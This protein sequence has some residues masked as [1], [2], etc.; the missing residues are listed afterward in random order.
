MTDPN[1][2]PDPI[3]PDDPVEPVGDADPQ[4]SD[5]PAADPPADA[6]PQEDLLGRLQRVS[7]DYVNY[8]KRAQRDIVQAREFANEQ[9]IKE[10]LPVLDDMERALDAARSNHDEDDP[11][12]KGMQL[13]HDKAL[14]VLK[15]FGVSIIEAQGQPLNPEVHAAMM[16]QPT[17]EVA[18]GTVLQEVQRGYLL[19]GRTIR[20]AAVVVA[21]APDDE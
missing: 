2:Q 5:E 9:L 1:R 6:D 18:P 15:N 21:K 16:Q 17:D 4:S 13:V 8:Q 20:P 14:A 11:L 7:A 19:K 12:L 3:E 10:L